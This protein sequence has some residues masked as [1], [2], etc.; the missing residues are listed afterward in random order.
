MPARS[1]DPLFVARF[2]VIVP[3]ACAAMGILSPKLR[4]IS[5]ALWPLL[6]LALLLAGCPPPGRH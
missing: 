4:S 6:A 3:V 5:A 1:F 2:R